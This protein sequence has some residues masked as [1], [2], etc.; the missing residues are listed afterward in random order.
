MKKEELLHKYFLEELS[1]EEHSE[2]TAL[3]EKDAEF[4][5]QFDF[6]R[7]VQRAIKSKKRKELQ[8]KIQGFENESNISPKGKVIIWRPLLIAASIAL[9]FSLGIYVFNPFKNDDPSRLYAESYQK[10]PNTVFPITRGSDQ[11]K[12]T[13]FQA[14]EAY[15]MNDDAKA[16]ELFK[17][18]QEEQS[19]DYINFYLGQS[20]LNNDQAQEAITQFQEIISNQ[21][22][23]SDEAQW[24]LA[25]AYLKNEDIEN[26]IK[27]LELIHSK[28]GYKAEET[29]KLLEVLRP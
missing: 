12:S 19:A 20:Y 26:A 27:A 7:S 21:Q 10:Y 29:E 1:Q 8:E 28:K 5:E 18:L 15:E 9:L 24:Y 3:L 13:E 22:Q 17:T 14:F 2:F 4:K 16:I 23:F 11:N 25:L 6:E